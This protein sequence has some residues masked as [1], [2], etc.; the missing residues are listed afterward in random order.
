V[1]ISE[2][3]ARRFWQD[4]ADAV[5]RR[6]MPGRPSDGGSWYT[7][8]G[9][10]GDA[11]YRGLTDGITDAL[12]YPFW[13]LRVGSR[14]VVYTNQLD[15]VVKT[16]LPAD[17]VTRSVVQAVW[18]VDPEVPVSDI[19][20]M[21]EVV[22]TASARTRFTMTLLI[23]AGCVALILGAV[24]LYG[25]I[26]Y[27]VS[28]RIREIGIRMALGANP[29]RVQRMV[30]QQGLVLA[31]SGMCLGLSAAVIVGRIAAAQ[32]YGVRPT[33]PTTF[34]AVSAAM[35]TVALLASYLPARRAAAMDP[36]ESLRFE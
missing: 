29:W 6:V 14:D 13:S 21:A 4:P 8:V 32:L 16:S 7:V 17:V 15:L 36:L 11:P 34:A 35:V 31:V 22:E 24:G 33:D 9:V 27:V 12:Y 20:T 30:L 10:V 5:G 3:L 18:T 1:V 26:S 23:A 19:R 25:V 28:R 2:S